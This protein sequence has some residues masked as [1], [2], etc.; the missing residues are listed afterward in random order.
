[1]VYINGEVSIPLKSGHIVI[2]MIKE[3]WSKI[4]KKVSI[5]LKSGHIVIKVV[6]QEYDRWSRFNP[7]KIGSYCNSRNIFFLKK[8]FVSI[9][10]KSGHIVIDYFE[11][12]DNN[13]LIVS[14]PLKSGHI[15]MLKN[16]LSW[17]IMK[18]Q[19]P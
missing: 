8:V 5:P 19:S 17:N 12:E 11:E 10:L 14:I 7:L 3:I 9:P 15:V 13:W 18:F 4:Q 2:Y 16:I 6:R 1:M